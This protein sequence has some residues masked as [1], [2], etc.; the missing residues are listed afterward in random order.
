MLAAAAAGDLLAVSCFV[1]CGYAGGSSAVLFAAAGSKLAFTQ[2]PIDWSVVAPCSWWL[3]LSFLALLP[4]QW[5]NKLVHS[6]QGCSLHI[7]CEAF[8]TRQYTGLSGLCTA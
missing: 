4:R 6:D 3:Q 7:A 8:A 2:Q 1:C 5:I